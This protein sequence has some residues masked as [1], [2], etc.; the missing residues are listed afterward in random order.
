MYTALLPP[1]V[2]IIAVNKIYRINSHHVHA[3]YKPIF[4]NSDYVN[5]R[6]PPT[7]YKLSPPLSYPILL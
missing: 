1:G 7:R 6:L 2:N 3:G 5:Y 4:V